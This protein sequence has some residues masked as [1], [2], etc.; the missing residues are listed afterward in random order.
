MY[1]AQLEKGCL[2][3]ACPNFLRDGNDCVGTI[4]TVVVTGC[5]PLN[6]GC[7]AV[8]YTEQTEQF[9]NTS[10]EDINHAFVGPAV[11]QS[12]PVQKLRNPL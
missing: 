6:I 2:G 1:S 12:H 5:T 8:R 9:C 3:E 7:N 11:K 10:P 4:E